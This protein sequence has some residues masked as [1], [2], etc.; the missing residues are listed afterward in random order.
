MFL[1]NLT[2][3]EKKAFLFLA[4]KVSKADNIV[5]EDELGMLRA[6]AQEMGLSEINSNLSEDEVYTI[7]T[8]SENKIKRAV[9]TELLSLALV[10]ETFEERD[11][12]CLK[13]IQEK[14]GLPEPFVKKAR[15]WLY[16]YIGKTKEGYMLIEGGI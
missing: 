16:S 10:D 12:E 7:L 14:L 2:E 5:T 3:N 9:Y 11:I 15:D 6:F 1:G 4:N 13:N 8:V